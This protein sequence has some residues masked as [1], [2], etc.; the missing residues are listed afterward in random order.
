[1]AD[2]QVRLYPDVVDWMEQIAYEWDCS[3]SAATNRVLRMLYDDALQ[4]DADDTQHGSYRDDDHLPDEIEIDTHD[5]NGEVKRTMRLRPNRRDPRG[6]HAR[7]A[8]I[9]E[10]NRQ[11]R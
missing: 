4:D 1:M 11:S 2:R 6:T 3:L 7:V 8:A 5:G 10:R 9:L